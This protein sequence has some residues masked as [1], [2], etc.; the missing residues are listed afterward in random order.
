MGEDILKK[1]YELTFHK[2]AIWEIE[3]YYEAMEKIKKLIEEHERDSE[4]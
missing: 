4:K 2:Y 1:I 3:D